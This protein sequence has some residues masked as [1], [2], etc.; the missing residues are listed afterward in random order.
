MNPAIEKL[1]D[2]AIL[3]DAGSGDV[4]TEAVYSGS[5]KSTG[6]F[7]A[8]EDGIIAGSELA[9]HI[10]KKIDNSLIYEPLISDGSEV[11]KGDEIARVSGSSGS[12]LTGERIALNFMQRMSGVATV[13]RKFVDKVS[14]TKCRILDTRKTIPGHRYTD[15][16]AVR[17]GGGYNHRYCL[18]DMYLIKENHI[19]VAGGIA[20]ALD[21]CIQH[22]TQ[23]EH[24]G[25]QVEIE[26]QNLDQINE[27]LD[28]GGADIIMLDNMDNETM[29]QAVALCGGQVQLE[30]SGNMSLERVKNVAETGVDFIS[31]G[32]LTHSVMAMDISLLFD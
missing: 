17:L 4:T 20:E 28:H 21:A 29:K 14:H 1:L 30:A 22:K 19:V 10:F 16:W 5:E 8:K 11:K 13:T 2:L 9:G 18:D 15:K 31:V 24:E 23:N 32:A 27:V 12:I 6:L 7:L 26:V 25:H 3:E